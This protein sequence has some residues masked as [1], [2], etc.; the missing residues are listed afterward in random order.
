MNEQITFKSILN[1]DKIAY[2]MAD[3]WNLQ[4][5]GCAPLSMY[6]TQFDTYGD[7]MVQHAGAWCSPWENIVDACMSLTT[8][9]L[10]DPLNK[11]WSRCG[12]TLRDTNPD[13]IKFA[14][15]IQYKEGKRQWYNSSEYKVSSAESKRF[16]K[17]WTEVSSW[18]DGSPK[19]ALS[20]ILNEV[21]GIDWLQKLAWAYDVREAAGNYGDWEE[22]FLPIKNLKGEWL[23]AFLALRCAVKAVSELERSRR[24]LDCAASNTQRQAERA[25]EEAAKAAAPGAGAETEGRRAIN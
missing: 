15:S 14:L 1:P 18:M 8:A 5:A 24:V 4:T 7:G 22:L 6:L 25:A 16:D 21:K 13:L 9:I 19:S 20:I 2:R 12:Y 23:R 11:V 17:R 3:E 10:A